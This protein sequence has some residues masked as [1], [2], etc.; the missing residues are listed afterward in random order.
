[1]SP[2][3]R[4]RAAAA[5]AVLL[6]AAGALAFG[7][8]NGTFAIFTGDTESPNA[9]ASGGWVNPAT[10]LSVSNYGYGGQVTFTVGNTGTSPFG[11]LTGSQAVYDVLAANGS[12]PTTLASYTIAGSVVSTSP[13]T[14]NGSSGNNLKYVC[15]GVRSFMNTWYADAY[16]ASPIQVGLIPQSFSTAA[17]GSKN[18]DIDAGDTI[19]INYNQSVSTAVSSVLICVYTTGAIVIGDTSIPGN[20]TTNAACSGSGADSASVGTIA[21]ASANSTRLFYNS[22]VMASGSSLIITVGHAGGNGANAYTAVTGPGTY[23]AQGSSVTSANGSPAATQCTTA[24]TCTPS[25]AISF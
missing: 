6:L 16:A 23:T 2:K 5:A 21:A 4:R 18:G 22:G 11:A 13:V 8:A 25:H 24:S 14:D 12:C 15:Y 10:G 1:M 7:Q 3:A 19:T 9:T 17:T 20:S